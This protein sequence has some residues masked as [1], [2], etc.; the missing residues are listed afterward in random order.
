[1]E[2]LETWVK[3][4]EKYKDTFRKRLE[5]VEIK[6]GK[7]LLHYDTWDETVLCVDYLR[8]AETVTEKWVTLN[9]AENV[10]WVA[11]NWDDLIKED[12]IIYFV[13]LDTKNNWVL[14]PKLHSMITPKKHLKKSLKGLFETVKPC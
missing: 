1:M 11:E 10:K 14:K 4:Y 5:T 3:E 2:S 8:D 12:V 9:T 6:D 13:N 7:V